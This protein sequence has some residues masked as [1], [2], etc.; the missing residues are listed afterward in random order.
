VDICAAVMTFVCVLMIIGYCGHL[1]SGNDIC[2]CIDDL[3]IM[4]IML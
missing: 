3:S 2:M 4:M 1:C